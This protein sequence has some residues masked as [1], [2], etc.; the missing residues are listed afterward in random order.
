MKKSSVMES[1]NFDIQIVQAE[2]MVACADTQSAVSREYQKALAYAKDD[3]EELNSAIERLRILDTLG[4]RL[5]HVRSGLGILVEG[6]ETISAQTSVPEQS[7]NNPL[8][9]LFIG[10]MVDSFHQQEPLF[11]KE[12][13][14]EAR[15]NIRD[16]L[17]EMQPDETSTVIFTSIAAGADIIFAEECLNRNLHIEILLPYAEPRYVADWIISVGDEWAS[18]YYNVRNH[19]NTIIRLQSELVG[20]PK[21]GANSLK[22]NGKWGVY[23]ALG[24]GVENVRLITLW[25]GNSA[26]PNRADEHLINHLIEYA[27]GFGIQINHINITRFNYWKRS[28]ETSP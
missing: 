2:V 24:F 19:A 21:W 7:N 8:A 20:S 9:I 22:R 10:H 6:L 27:R 12:M 4:F 16:S 13:E 5:E 3:L 15:E 17:S 23:S 18:R 26:Y 25:N 28:R 14:T 11:P 1:A